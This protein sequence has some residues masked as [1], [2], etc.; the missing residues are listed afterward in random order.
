MIKYFWGEDDF[1][2]SRAIAEESAKKSE[3]VVNHFGKGQVEDF[4]MSLNSVSFF[5]PNRIL[6][7]EDASEGLKDKDKKLLKAN[8]RDLDKNTTIIVREKRAPIK[9]WVELGA[10]VTGFVVLKGPELVRYIKEKVKE[11]GG[12]I[13]PLAAERL[14]GY[15]GSDL[16]QLEEEIKKLVLYKKTDTVEVQPI[17]TADVDLLVHANFEANIFNLVDAIA[18]RNTK[19]A[20]KL[21]SSFIEEGE[22]PLYLLSMV[23]RQIRN[24]AMVKFESVSKDVFANRAGVHPY[25]AQ[26]TIEQA[27]N[28][29]ERDVKEFYEKLVRVDLSLK[30]GGDP[31]Q[32]LQSLI[33]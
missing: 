9:F 12:D 7:L 33:I 22:N 26:K 28:F 29:S 13:A 4:I 1:R 17:E 2:I 21:L 16:W 24:I 15:V 19:K 25:V 20:E 31:G 8:L 14:A 11:L 30:S 3:A 18:S 5:N 6:I 27:K 32:A 23:T 10:T